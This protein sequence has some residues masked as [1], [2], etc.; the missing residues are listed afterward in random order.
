MTSPKWTN[1]SAEAHYVNRV[2]KKKNISPEKNKI[3][4]VYKNIWNL[5]P[6][7]LGPHSTE[8]TFCVSSE[9]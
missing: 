9:V 2:G 3:R 1:Q 4:Y 5:H 7:P 6:P 8:K